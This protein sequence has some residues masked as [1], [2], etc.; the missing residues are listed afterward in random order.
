M[1]FMSVRV[2]GLLVLTSL[3]R[4]VLIFELDN[5]LQNSHGKY[6]RPYVRGKQHGPGN[7]HTDNHRP[8]LSKVSKPDLDYK[9][10]KRSRPY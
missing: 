7:G 1:Q 4:L 8:F 10:L 2:L 9:L 3:K 5:K 6:C